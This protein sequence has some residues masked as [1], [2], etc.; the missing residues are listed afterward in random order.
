MLSVSQLKLLSDTA[1]GVGRIV[2]ANV[3][4]GVVLRIPSCKACIERR[5]LQIDVAALLNL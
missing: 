4:R 1:H 2:G 3:T 5:H